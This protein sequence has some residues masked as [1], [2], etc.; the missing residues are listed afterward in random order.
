MD[1]VENTI[2][3]LLDEIQDNLYKNSENTLKDNTT[4]VESFSELIDVLNSKKGFVSCFWKENKEDEV[5]I[6]EETSATLR[7]Y[8]LEITETEKSVNSDSENGK[9]AIFS[10]AY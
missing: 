7:C 2:K 4:H 10:K 3:K 5:K 8:P 6:K 9:F 1:D